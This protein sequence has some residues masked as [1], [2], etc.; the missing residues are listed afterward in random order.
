MFLWLKKYE[1]RRRI[2]SR[3]P[4]DEEYI[5]IDV[6][7]TTHLRLAQ[8]NIIIHTV[9]GVHSIL[10]ELC[11]PLLFHFRHHTL[12]IHHHTNVGRTTLL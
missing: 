12:Y 6:A 9:F 11:T 5:Y 7:M 4:N 1:R 3:T 2:S 10:R 8:H